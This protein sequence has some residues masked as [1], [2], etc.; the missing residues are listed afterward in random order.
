M[1]AIFPQPIDGDLLDLVH[2]SNGFR[3]LG[4]ASPLHVGDIVKT[5]AKIASVINTDA[6]KVVEV[7]G[8]IIHEGNPSS[9]PPLSS[10]TAATSRTTK[11][12]LRFSKSPTTWLNTQPMVPSAFSSRKG[13]S[14]CA[15]SQN[16][17][18]REPLSLNSS[19]I[20]S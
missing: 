5:E 18:Q 17:L 3:M 10:S 15:I 13:G 8:N 12:P 1:K 6:G 7:I 4:G 14:S 19:P 9:R 20:L 11:T 2:L 16:P